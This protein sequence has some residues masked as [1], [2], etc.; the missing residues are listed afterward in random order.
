MSQSQDKIDAIYDLRD[1]VEAKVR[2]EAAVND[3]PSADAREALLDATLE[4]E[5]RTQHAIEV[6]H[7]CGHVHP[8][9]RGHVAGA[10][11]NNLI[12]VNFRPEEADAAR[13]AG[14]RDGDGNAT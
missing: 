1:A 6:C 11:A 14:E 13:E 7:E 12:R 9:D 10:N 2:L 4:V 3:R 8:G 5:A